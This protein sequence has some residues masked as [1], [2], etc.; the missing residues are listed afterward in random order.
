MDAE[1][2]DKDSTRSRIQILNYL[3]NDK[4]MYGKLPKALLKV[5]SEKQ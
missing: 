1:N 4:M 5:H 2:L 3:L